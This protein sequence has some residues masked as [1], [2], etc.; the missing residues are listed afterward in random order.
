MCFFSLNTFQQ[1]WFSVYHPLHLTQIST[2]SSSFP[3]RLSS[4]TRYHPYPAPAI[5]AWLGQMRTFCPIVSSESFLPG[6]VRMPCSWEMREICHC[7]GITLTRVVRSKANSV[8]QES[9]ENI[10]TWNGY[11]H[12]SSFR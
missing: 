6:L 2:I 3:S 7:W 12:Q 11:V 8:E 5:H 9:C 1:W 4:T 10:D